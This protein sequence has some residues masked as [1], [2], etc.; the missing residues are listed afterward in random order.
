MVY[1]MECL[2]VK[3]KRKRKRNL[4]M[5]FTYAGKG[6]DGGGI[7]GITAPVNG[8]TVIIGSST[9]LLSDM[10]PFNKVP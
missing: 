9:L 4:I 5:D 10:M 8:S 6:S 7:G 1:K 3:R 2:R